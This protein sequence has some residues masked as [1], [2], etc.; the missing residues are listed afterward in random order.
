MNDCR[1]G[2]I[3]I[4]NN[5]FDIGLAKKLTSSFRTNLIFNGLKVVAGDQLITDQSDIQAII[6]DLK[7]KEFDILL[8]FQATF[9]DSKIM[10]ALIEAIDK[11]IFLWAIPEE[12]SGG[13]L[14]LNSLSGANLAAHFLQLRKKQYWYVYAKI[15]DAPA[16]RNV[17][18]AAVSVKAACL[19]RNARIGVV[20]GRPPGIETSQLDSLELRE[21]F[22]VEIVNIELTSLFERIESLDLIKISFAYQQ[23]EVKLDNLAEL[24]QTALKRTLNA[25]VVLREIS[26]EEDLDGFAIGCGSEFLS[27]LGC[28]ACGVISMLIENDIPCSCEADVNGVITEIILHSL[29][30]S[31]AVGMNVV[32]ADFKKDQFVVRSC[33]LAP[34]SMAD[35]TVQ[36]RGSNSPTCDLPLQMEFPLKQGKVTVARLSRA[37]GCLRLVIGR[38]EMISAP[39]SFIGTSGVFRFENTSQEV[40]DTIFTEGLEHRISGTYGSY[41][42]GLLHLARLFDLPVLML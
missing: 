2:L 8:I 9:T 41:T 11:P 12:S 15:D 32:S 29:S 16:F 4:A 23:L 31:P 37:Q 38:G 19:L 35:P 5:S 26:K 39:M 21:K 20:G 36:A 42:D 14:R 33:G 10:T 25:F 1:V 24:E 7:T 17:L 27:D 13:N 30:G 34:L 28:S 22:G 40:L 18:S 3:P 6:E